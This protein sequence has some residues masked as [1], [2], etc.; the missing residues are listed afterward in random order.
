MSHPSSDL[1]AASQPPYIANDPHETSGVQAGFQLP[2]WIWHS[3][4]AFYA[5]FFIAVA[6]ATGRDTV[7]VMMLVISL[8]YMLMFF[9]TAGLLHKQKGREHDSPLDRAGGLLETWTGPMD[10]RTVAAQILAVPAGFAFLGIVVFLARAS[11]G[12]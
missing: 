6:A 12:F 4:F 2:R 10:T 3:M 1:P 8:L 5:I 11:A 9:G 7:T